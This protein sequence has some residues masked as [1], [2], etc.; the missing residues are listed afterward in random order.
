VKFT[1]ASIAS[2]QLPPGKTDFIMFDTETAGFGIRLRAGGRRTWVAQLRIGGHTRRISI[3]SVG[4]IELDVARATAKRFFAESILGT[5]PIAA[6]AE[7]K[8]RAATTVGPTVE[9]YLAGRETTVRP[10]T[11]K[12][13]T[14]YLRSYFK[15][16]HPLP[17]SLVT[18]RHVAEAVTRIAAEHGKVAAARA[19]TALSGFFTWALKEGI[20]GENN[21]VS[22]TNDPAP[23]EKPRERTLSP[24]EL[25]ALWLALPDTE[26]GTITKL[27]LLT[28]CRRAEIGSLEWSEVDLDKASLTIRPE[29][30]KGGK[31]HRLPLVP[32]A[33]ELLRQ[34]PRRV[35][36]K[37]V[38]G[39]NRKGFSGFS[40]P[41]DELRRALAATGAITEPWSLHDL[42]RSVRTQL[43]ELEVDP[44]IAERILAHARHGIEATY[45]WSKL[46]KPMRVALLKWNDRLRS[47]IEDTEATVVQLRH[48]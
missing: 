44:W 32:E 23:D 8:A 6:R 42:R 18:R 30:M 25:R 15:Q 36:N 17:V 9:L 48:G 43:S 11:R 39:A 20:G 24:S 22:N 13:T 45:D 14:R 33:V 34:V 7:A 29:R 40:G 41:V 16:L 31:T 2:L 12:Q 26:F 27:L 5:D 21:P 10:S 35:D 28:A 3:G 38:F 4:R 1:K 37:F 46:E 47:I 19:R